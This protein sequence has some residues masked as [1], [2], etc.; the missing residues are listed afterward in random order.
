MMTNLNVKNGVY[1]FSN[2]KTPMATEPTPPHLLWWQ[3]HPVKN[4]GYAFRK[5]SIFMLVTEPTP[6]YF[7]EN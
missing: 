4:G 7:G 2:K 5:P 3:L 6:H 1:I